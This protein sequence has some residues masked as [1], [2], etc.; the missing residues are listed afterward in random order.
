[1]VDAINLNA[2]NTVTAY[3]IV[4]SAI[5][6]LYIKLG[7][8]EVRLLEK[9][10]ASNGSVP[11]FQVNISGLTWIQDLL[12]DFGVDLSGVKDL[13]DNLKEGSMNIGSSNTLL[14]GIVLRLLNS[15]V[16]KG[17]SYTE[18]ASYVTETTSGGETGGETGG[19]TDEGSFDI[20][21]LGPILEDV[22]R[23][24]EMFKFNRV[25]KDTLTLTVNE[26][27]MNGAGVSFEATAKVTRDT[28]DTLD[29]LTLSL[30]ANGLVINGSDDVD[31]TLKMV[32]GWP[33]L[34]IGGDDSLFKAA[35][36]AV[37]VDNRTGV[38][39]ADKKDMNLTIGLNLLSIGYGVVPKVDEAN[40]QITSANFGSLFSN[41][42]LAISVNSTTATE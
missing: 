33:L 35:I 18:P 38:A 32:K 10:V 40:G 3:E 19:N 23:Y 24:I 11:T 29:S 1:M 20:S 25:D 34:Q 17:F 21:K 8:L 12:K 6:N 28:D 27:N 5:D 4:L 26:T 13:F 2:A 41:P 16:V 39:D 14:R 42:N 37:V 22:V 30:G 7:D 36:N 9:D 15:L 31:T